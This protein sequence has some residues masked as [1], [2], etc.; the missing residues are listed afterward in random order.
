MTISYTITNRFSG[1]PQFTAEIDCAPDAPE[2]VKRGL[3]VLWALKN[4]AYLTDADLTGADLRRADLRDADLT[5]ADLRGADL[6]DADLTGAV[7][8]DTIGNGREI[9]TIQ[10]DNW[11][12]VYTADVMQ[13][14]CQRHTIKDWFRFSDADI[15]KMDSKALEWWGRWKPRLTDIISDLE[16]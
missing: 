4:G 9:K 14:G 6:T 5:G 1:A 12:V 3:V 11:T 15:G 8:W 10:T 2:S 7:L 16:K 13:I